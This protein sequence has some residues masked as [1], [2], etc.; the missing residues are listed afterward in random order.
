MRHIPM[1]RSMGHL[2][3]RGLHHPYCRFPFT[4]FDDDNPDKVDIRVDRLV[5]ELLME[6][7][8]HGTKVWTLIA[9]TQDG[10]WVGYYCFGVGNEGHKK[11][12]LEWSGYLSAHIRFHLI[13]QGFDNAEINNLIK[14]SFDFQEQRMQHR[15]WWRKT[16]VSSHS[17]R[18]RRSKIFS[19]MTRHNIGWI[20][21]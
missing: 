16:N 15:Q 18:W 12:A 10:R 4:K 13:S 9:Q 11:L 20:S 17:D 5:R 19:I 2:P 8:I 3:I 6:K 14:G 21:C 1:V 7:M